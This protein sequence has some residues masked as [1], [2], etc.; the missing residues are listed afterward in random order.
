[1]RKKLKYLIMY[2]KY[3]VEINQLYSYSLKGKHGEQVG[4]DWNWYQRTDWWI[5]AM[6]I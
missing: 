3:H 2:L 1:M 6:A 4:E 5:R